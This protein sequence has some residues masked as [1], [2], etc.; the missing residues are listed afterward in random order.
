MGSTLWL[1]PSDR[2]E[3]LLSVR[4]A[5][6]R[7]DTCVGSSRISGGSLPVYVLSQ[8]IALAVVSCEATRVAREIELRSA[9]VKSVGSLRWERERPLLA[10]ADDGSEGSVIA[11]VSQQ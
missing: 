3:M 11:V 6:L 10:A 9:V 7:V 2:T 8:R 5:T 4:L 1:P